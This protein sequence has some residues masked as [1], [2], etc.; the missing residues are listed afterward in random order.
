MLLYVFYV[1]MVGLC[2]A[3][4]CVPVCVV[5]IRA[6][7]CVHSTCVYVRTVRVYL[8]V[9]ACTL[10]FMA[11]EGVPLELFQLL[12]HYRQIGPQIGLFC[13]GLTPH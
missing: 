1:D 10:I 4:L 7:V 3:V 12:M 5:C 6:Y 9:C 8:C 13:C 11:P 2:L